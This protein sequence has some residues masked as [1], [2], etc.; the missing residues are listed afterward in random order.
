MARFETGKPKSR[1]FWD[2]ATH[3]NVLSVRVRGAND[4]TE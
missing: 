4:D 2:A 1:R 3:G